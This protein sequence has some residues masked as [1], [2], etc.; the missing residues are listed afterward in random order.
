MQ[1]NKELLSNAIDLIVGI[2]LL[3]LYFLE[4]TLIVDY[5]WHIVLVLL[6]CRFLIG[7]SRFIQTH[8]SWPEDSNKKKNKHRHPRKRK[9]NKKASDQQSY[10]NTVLFELIKINTSI[11]EPLIIFKSSERNPQRKCLSLN[12]MM[13]T[14]CHIFYCLLSLLWEESRTSQQPPLESLSKGRTLR[15]SGGR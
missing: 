1:V 8:T 12:Q 15:S 2:V 14:N 9:K 3:I 4:V 10:L 7:K 11:N 5:L 6:G 13:R